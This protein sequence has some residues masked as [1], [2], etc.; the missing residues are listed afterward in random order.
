MSWTALPK[1][2]FVVFGKAPVCGSVPALAAATGR[3]DGFGGDGLGFGVG[4]AAGDLL[5]RGD[6]LAVALTEPVVAFAAVGLAEA[7]PARAL[8]SAQAAMA[9]VRAA[10]RCPWTSLSLLVTTEEATRR[11]ALPVR[12]PRTSWRF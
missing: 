6:G 11:G 8:T 7:Q 1:A 5:A 9:L 3:A 12:R 10:R 4:G 2:V